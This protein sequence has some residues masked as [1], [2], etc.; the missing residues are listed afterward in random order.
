MWLSR[1]ALGDTCKLFPGDP[2]QGTLAHSLCP[3]LHTK[4]MRGALLL[5]GQSW[6]P[7]ALAAGLIPWMH[8]GSDSKVKCHLQRV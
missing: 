8:V 7:Q 1:T 5:K 3:L 4:L 6:G 2:G